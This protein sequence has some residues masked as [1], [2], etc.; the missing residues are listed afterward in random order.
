MCKQKNTH[1]QMHVLPLST[2]SFHFSHREIILLCALNDFGLTTI[3]MLGNFISFSLS[4]I[5]TTAIGIRVN[6]V[7]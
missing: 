2:T 4:G 5:L 1:I 3:D 6:T 7:C